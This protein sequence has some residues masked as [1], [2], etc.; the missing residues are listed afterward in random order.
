MLARRDVVAAW[1]PSTTASVGTIKLGSRR[2]KRRTAESRVS[3]VWSTIVQKRAA[4]RLIRKRIF[5]DE[6]EYPGSVWLLACP[7]SLAGDGFLG[8]LPRQ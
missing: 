4:L 5:A 3:S 6:L 7:S 2:Q 8:R 1:R